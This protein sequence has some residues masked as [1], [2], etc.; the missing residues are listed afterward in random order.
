MC[1]LAGAAAI[2]EF[3][4]SPPLLREQYPEAE[5]MLA[6]LSLKITAVSGVRRGFWFS[7]IYSSLLPLA[8]WFTYVSTL[9]PSV[10]VKHSS[11]NC[12]LLLLFLHSQALLNWNKL[13]GSSRGGR[14]N[15][16]TV[17]C[18]Q[19]IFSKLG[20]LA[21]SYHQVEWWFGMILPQSTLWII[22]WIL[23]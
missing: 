10:F 14:W 2:K 21:G 4:A 20:G 3:K 15:K 18:V 23:I 7:S 5:N 9:F 16:K 12:F 13:L 17:G 22:W 19:P 11:P 8:T 1:L 6:D